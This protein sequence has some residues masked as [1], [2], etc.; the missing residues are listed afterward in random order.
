MPHLK[1]PQS[2]KLLQRITPT[3]ACFTTE[4]IEST[5]TVPRIH[6][7]IDSKQ[8]STAL[9]AGLSLQR[10][11]VKFTR[12]NDDLLPFE[13]GGEAKLEHFASKTDCGQFVLASHTKKRPHN[14]I[15]GRFFD[16]RLYDLLELGV[17]NY[18]AIKSFGSA[19][20]GVQAE[21]KVGARGSA[22]SLTCVRSG[23]ST[24][25]ALLSVCMAL[26]S[27][28][29]ALLSVCMAL[30]SECMALLSV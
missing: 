29:M 5:D 17:V 27:V 28:C 19:A 25:M 21:N 9:N 7:G 1:Y 10:Q 14:L 16:H 22:P 8:V 12:K 2:C 15:L 30:L 18:R 3:H 6:W 20:S 4:S 23:I 13:A 26:L 24:C 11:A